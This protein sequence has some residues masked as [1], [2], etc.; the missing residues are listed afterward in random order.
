HSMLVSAL[1]NAVDLREAVLRHT[2]LTFAVLNG[3]ELTNADLSSALLSQTVIARC[4]S[5]ATAR[6]LDS[7]ELLTASS[8]DLDTLRHALDH[9]PDELLA[10]LGADGEQLAALRALGSSA[11]R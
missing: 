6:G 10:K 8:I 5:L 11:S 4:P 1:F 9:L 3:A 2:D 7:L